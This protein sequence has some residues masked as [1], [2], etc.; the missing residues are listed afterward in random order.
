MA[1][2]ADFQEPMDAVDTWGAKWGATHYS[3]DSHGGVY[4]YVPQGGEWERHRIYYSHRLWHV[5]EDTVYVK[6]LPDA[7]H[8]IHASAGGPPRTRPD[9][10]LNEARALETSDSETPEEV[11]A[12]AYAYWMKIGPGRMHSEMTPEEHRIRGGASGQGGRD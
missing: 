3:E 6:R 8:Q 1:T 10:R 9:S 4:L 5:S 11:E 2:A 12:R 7:A